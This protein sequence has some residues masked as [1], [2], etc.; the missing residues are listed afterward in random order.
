MAGKR[1]RDGSLVLESQVQGSEN[2]QVIPISAI[3][4]AKLKLRSPESNAVHTAVPVDP[5]VQQI[6]SDY[7]ELESD[8]E[9]PEAYHNLKLCTWQHDEKNVLSESADQLTVS[10]N[11]NLTISLIGCYYF[12]VRKGAISINGANFASNMQKGLVAPTYRAFVPS[13]HPI[14]IIRGLDGRNEIQ[15]LIYKEPT[16]FRSIS[17][18]YARIWNAE[19][20]GKTQRSFSIVTESRTDPLQRA[21]FPEIVPED[22]TRQI[23]DCANN[24]S[25]TLISGDSLTGK[26]TFAKRLLNRLLTGFG[27]NARP[28]PA[29]YYLDLDANKPEYSPHGQISLVLVKE[30][31][32]GPSF[33]HPCTVPFITGKNQTVRAHSLPTGDIPDLQD[34]FLACVQNLFQTYDALRHREPGPLIINLPGWLADFDVVLRIMSYVKPHQIVYLYDLESVDE[35]AAAKLEAFGALSR[36]MGFT[37]HQVSAQTNPNTPSHSEAELRSMHMLSYFHF[38]GLKGSEG[39]HPT[40]NPKPLSYMTP[41]E[42]HY[43]ETPASGQNFSGFLT[44]GAWVEPSQLATLLNGSIVQIVE[45]EDESIQQQFGSFPRTKKLRLPYF[46][47]SE[48][49]MVNTLNPR[50][51]RLVCTALLR[52]FNPLQRVAQ[53]LVPKSHETLMHG[54][55]PEKTVLVF[56]A[57]EHPEWAYTE[58]AYHDMFQKATDKG[59]VPWVAAASLVEKMGYMNTTRRVRKF[60]Q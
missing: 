21:I 22:W 26:S 39:A 19:A 2:G 9:S 45:T 29:V 12:V 42:L 47:K 60:Q 24:Q 48:N 56:G 3:A 53:I 1:R 20:A 38:T 52:G 32:L 25:V 33:T 7:E 36:K 43:E 10:L 16:P 50:T 40:W 35:H 54:L 51:S 27:K 41:W 46:D 13:T 57:C 44:L 5:H 17:P 23:E 14:S 28:L 59:T 37:F 49:G 15:F 18:L 34:Y 4:A 6:E 8:H 58:D 31:N 55:V 30:V 11:R